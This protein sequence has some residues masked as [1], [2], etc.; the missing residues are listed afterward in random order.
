M[1]GRK[2][3]QPKLFHQ[4]NLEERVPQD[5]LLRRIPPTPPNHGTIVGFNEAGELPPGDPTDLEA[6]A[7][8][9]AIA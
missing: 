6:G 3:F 9:C 7:N 4:V 1:L 8:R 5:H 2:T